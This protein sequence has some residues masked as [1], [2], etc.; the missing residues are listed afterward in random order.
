MNRQ[1]IFRGKRLD[2][3]EWV[4]GDL[5]YNRAKNI[6]RIHTYDNNGE[7][8]MQHLVKPDSVGQFTGLTDK[9]DS[10][11]YDGD[12]VEAYD[13]D[14][15]LAFMGAVRYALPDAAFG[16]DKGTGAS[17]EPFEGNMTYK[18]VGNFHDNIES[19]NGK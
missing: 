19:L 18:V 4:Y 14:E 9:N 7:Y 2:N 13:L 16:I 6:A 8:L 17:L 12:I 5:E 10:P 11:I 15:E 3:G 1:I